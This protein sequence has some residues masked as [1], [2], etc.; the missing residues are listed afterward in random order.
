MKTRFIMIRHGFSVANDMRRFAGNFD[1]DLTETGKKQANLCAEALKNEKIDA[2]YS[3]D[4]KRAYDTAVPISETL[5]IE[6][7]KCP[8][9][10][11]IS[12]GEWEGKL[13]D[14]LCEEYP[15]AYSTWRNDIGNAVCTGGESVKQLS[16]RILSALCDIA[17]KNDGKTVCIT[18]HATPIRA[19]CTAAAGLPTEQMSKINW[20]GNASF[21][22]FDYEDGK[23]TAIK[24]SDMAHLGELKT[25]LPRN[26]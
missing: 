17:K 18:T 26:V 21:N 10:R 20:V 15:E 12:A 3:S 23:F 11:E 7:I 5:G 14:E 8:E 19:V 22:I 16:A 1:V 25:G 2:I 9:L 6:I 4:L 24:L 13:F